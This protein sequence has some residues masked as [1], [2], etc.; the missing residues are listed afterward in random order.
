MNQ[1]LKIHG[2][3]VVPFRPL[4]RFRGQVR[5]KTIGFVQSD[6]LKATGDF[7]RVDGP[8]ETWLGLTP[9]DM[10]FEMSSVQP[11]CWLMIGDDTSQYCQFF[12]GE[13][14][15]NL[16]SR[17]ISLYYHPE[18]WKNQGLLEFLQEVKSKDSC[19]L[20]GSRRP[21]RQGC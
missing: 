19:R 21:S 17:G 11:P 12:M 16:K 9:E 20:P 5:V 4:A 3:R 10:D 13:Y 8:D 7:G 18:S 6:I 14:Y 1:S 2:F 15:G